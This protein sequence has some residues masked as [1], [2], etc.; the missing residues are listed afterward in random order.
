MDK[1]GVDLVLRGLRAFDLT[2]LDLL[3]D[4]GIINEQEFQERFNKRYQKLEDVDKTYK[5]IQR[6]AG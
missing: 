5:E 2:I 3:T 4:K 1:Q 6:L